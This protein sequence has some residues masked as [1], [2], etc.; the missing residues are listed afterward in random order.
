MCDEFNVLCNYPLNA[1]AAGLRYLE[2]VKQE[3]NTTSGHSNVDD[4]DLARLEEEV[5]LFPGEYEIKVFDEDGNIIQEHDVDIP[6]P[7]GL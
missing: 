6:L 2:L 7:K 1:N 4:L 5:K 3:F